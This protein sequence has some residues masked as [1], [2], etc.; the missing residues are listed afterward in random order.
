MDVRRHIAALGL[1]VGVAGSNE[2][3]IAAAVISSGPGG[4][5]LGVNDH[6]H[7]NFAG[8]GLRFDATGHDG[9]AAGCA[10]EGWGV[11]I[12]SLASSGYASETEGGAVNLSLVS[13]EATAER[14]RA[15]VTVDNGAGAPVLRVTHDYRPSPLTNRVYEVS[16]R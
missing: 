8:V 9:I 6:G 16:V 3:A 14:A 11:G 12:A 15:V 1:V 5:A 7:L 4:V 2:A 13:F 10:G